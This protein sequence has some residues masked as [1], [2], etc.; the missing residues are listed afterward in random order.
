MLRPGLY[1]LHL[2]LLLCP[3]AGAQDADAPPATARW[4]K[5]NLHTH[6]LWS[7]GDD[8]P[9]MIAAWYKERGYHFLALSDH[10]VL[11]E[12]SRWFSLTT[13]RGSG[14]VLDRYRARF[15]AAWVEERQISGT[16][17]VRLKPLAEYR[18]RLEE[19]DRFLLVPSMEITDRHLT[20]PVHINATNP[21]EFLPAA[22]GSNVLDVMRRN[23]NAVLDQRQRTGQPMFPHI[24]HPNFGWGITAEELM[25]VEGERF[26]EVYNGHPSVHNDGDASHAGLDRVWDIVLTWRLAKLNL[27]PVYGL[28]VDDSHHYHTNAVGQSNPGRGWVMVR[29]PHLTAEAL[30]H[31]LEAGEFYAS[32]GVILA[33]ITRDAKSLRLRIETQPGITYRTQFIGTRKQFDAANEPV[34]LPSGDAARVTHRYSEDVGRVLAESEA[35]EPA[36][37]FRGDELYVRARITSSRLKNNGY[38]DGEFESAWVQPVIP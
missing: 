8:Y 13:P 36:Y 31:A 17:Q 6:S 23:V 24:N 20:A 1:L 11:Q 38:R 21:R 22:G 9:E 34:R 28:A 32:S 33:D 10:N 15:G 27:P 29:A 14:P 3:L 35:T 7:D 18:T 25:H 4:W 30:V 26:F 5:G 12:G 37:T 2:L 19:P 16:N